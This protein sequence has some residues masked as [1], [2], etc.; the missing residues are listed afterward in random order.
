MHKNTAIS[1]L[2]HLY[3]RVFNKQMEKVFSV[4]TFDP[5]S[6]LMLAEK[7]GLVIFRGNIFV[8]DGESLL[9]LFYSSF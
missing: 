8:E 2:E 5:H 3:L 7:L 4:G 9:V 1:V 6:H